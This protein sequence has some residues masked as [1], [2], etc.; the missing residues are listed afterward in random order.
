MT[1][2][3]ALA[4]GS[5]SAAGAVKVTN[6]GKMVVVDTG[7]LKC[8]IPTSGSDLVG[9]M[10]V[11]GK[12]I[13]GA[14]QLVCI[15]QNGPETNP[16]DAASRERYVGNVK[17]VTVEQTGPVRAV[18]KIEGMHRGVTSGRE[19]LPFTVRLYFY[20]GETSVRVVHTIVY[21]GDQEKDFVRGL[22]LQFAVPLRDEPR[23]RTVRFAGADGGVWSEPLQPG[24]GSAAQESG[25]SFQGS[26]VFGK[27]AIW[28]DFKLVQPSPERLPRL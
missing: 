26:P 20:S 21:D 11:G 25:T 4:A 28:D 23:N 22:G 10:S 19:W 14:G 6:D 3:V 24:G 5:S 1:G 7:A 8:S 9:S 27:N 15:L 17:K 12:D 16:E 18:V 13:G 2:P